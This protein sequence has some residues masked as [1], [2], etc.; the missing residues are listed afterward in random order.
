MMI[1]TIKFL[2][3]SFSIYTIGKLTKLYSIKPL[4]HALLAAVVL[5]VVNVIIRPVLIILTLPIS[6]LTLGIFLIFVNGFCLLIVSRVIPSF[7]LNGCFNAAIA[8]ILISI[9]NIVL[10]YILIGSA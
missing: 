2:I 7:K 6:I 10:S 8:S 5:S 4:S 3:L 1:L 9:V